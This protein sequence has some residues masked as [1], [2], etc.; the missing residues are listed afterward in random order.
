MLAQPQA[1]LTFLSTEPVQDWV[2]LGALGGLCEDSRAAQQCSLPVVLR[3]AATLGFCICISD[4]SGV[5]LPLCVPIPGRACTRPYV[6]VCVCVRENVCVSVRKCL[7][8]S[9][10]VCA[11]TSKKQVLGA[12]LPCGP[13]SLCN[14]VRLRCVFVYPLVVSG[15]DCVCWTLWTCFV[16]LFVLRQ[17]L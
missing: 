1:G 13:A 14:H 10:C 6:H 4:R 16:F 5:L 7:C 2:C 12:C 3:V 11:P 9:V 17:N 8:V 15:G